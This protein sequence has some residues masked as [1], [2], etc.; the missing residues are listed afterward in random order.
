MT[1]KEIL[2]GLTVALVLAFFIS[3]F[4]SPWPDGL[5]KVAE[6]KGFLHK[7][8]S[9]SVLISPVPDYAW[10]GIRREGIATGIAGIAG[11]LLIFSLAYGTGALLKRRS[12]RNS[13]KGL[14]Y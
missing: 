5:E 2:F 8:E 10:P 9:G 3:P 14:D 13:K 11:T 12:A 7:G 4:A 6:E 1:G